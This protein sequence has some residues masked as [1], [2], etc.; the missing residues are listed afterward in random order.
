MYDLT[1]S[2]SRTNIRLAGLSGSALFVNYPSSLQTPFAV[3]LFPDYHFASSDLVL[4]YL[5]R[6]VLVKDFRIIAIVGFT[7][8]CATPCKGREKLR[9]Y[10]R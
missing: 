9:S 1:H 8:I 7:K 10:E 4:S 2:G 6:C 3:P 5:G